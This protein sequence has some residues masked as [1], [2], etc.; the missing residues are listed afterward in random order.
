MLKEFF[1]NLFRRRKAPAGELWMD[2][3]CHVFNVDYLV[4]EAS[5]IMY[6]MLRG[7]YP[8]A[9]KERREGLSQGKARKLSIAGRA[10]APDQGVQRFI[11]WAL[12][13][14]DAGFD[15]EKGNADFIRKTGK[16]SFKVDD[17]GLMPLMMDIYYMYAPPLGSESVAEALPGFS[18]SGGQEEESDAEKERNLGAFRDALANLVTERRQSLV[19]LSSGAREAR[20]RVASLPG[21][22]EI[23]EKLSARVAQR[24]RIPD[25][26]RYEGLYLTK[27][28]KR[29]LKGILELSASMPGR[30]FP[31]FALDP[32]RPGAVQAV[33]S[34]KVVSRDGP[35]YGVKL[36]PRL[37]Y[38]PLCRELEPVYAYC[39][40][41]GLPITSHTSYKGFP[42]WAM[43]YADFGNP[44]NWERVVKDYPRLKIDLAHFG[45]RTGT[46]EWRKTIAR[47]IKENKNVYSDLSCYTHESDIDLVVNAFFSDEKVRRRTLFGSDFDVMYFTNPGEITLPDYY[48][49]FLRKLGAE[50]MTLMARDNPASFLRDRP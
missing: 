6:D 36:Y 3:H 46:G 39:A 28:F 20:A 41:N 26:E 43:E 37:G 10:G 27:G 32:R 49:V 23:V 5:Q 42:D 31:F 22:D 45:D 44:L 35:F 48:D 29:Q 13:T 30:V 19:A 50:T 34:G 14:L 8:M 7:A 40:Q 15:S 2:A 21:V 25:E 17:F 12:E 1:L 24:E 11:Q 38:H 33:L 16:S 47:L 9:E 4:S 18:G